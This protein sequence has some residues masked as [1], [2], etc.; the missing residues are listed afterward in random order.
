MT[1][2]TDKTHDERL[3]CDVCI[4]AKR[5]GAPGI[6]TTPA[7]LGAPAHRAARLCCNCGRD[8]DEQE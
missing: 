6:L 5:R 3:L 7:I 4:R 1:Q 2:I 8:R